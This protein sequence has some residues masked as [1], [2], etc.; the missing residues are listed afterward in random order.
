MPA[1]VSGAHAQWLTE[2]FAEWPALGDFMPALASQYVRDDGEHLT[3]RVVVESRHRNIHG[4]AHG[5][6]LAALA[7]V[8]L[9]YNVG[10]RLP[11][12][13]RIVTANLSVDYLA[14]VH[15]GDVLESQIDRIRIGSRLCHASGAILGPERVVVA[16]RATFAVIEA[17]VEPAGEGDRDR[18]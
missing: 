12:E 7:D 8:W 13:R 3:F 4:S 10:R 18:S 1:T 16:M 2:G 9:G 5:G 15:A 11:P 17:R 6:F 14:P